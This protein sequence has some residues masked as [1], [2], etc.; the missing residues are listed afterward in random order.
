M[1]PTHQGLDTKN[2][3][4]S[5][6]IDWPQMLKVLLDVKRTGSIPCYHVT[7]HKADDTPIDDNRAITWK[8][9]FDDIKQRCLL[10]ADVKLVWVIV[11]G[12]MLYWDLVRNS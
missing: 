6:T 8:T 11:E 7:S 4:S 9:Y 1:I 2:W 5:S 12:F 10:T 3:D